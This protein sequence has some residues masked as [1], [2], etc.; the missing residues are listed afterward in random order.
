[1]FREGWLRLFF[2]CRYKRFITLVTA[3]ASCGTVLVIISASWHKEYFKM[4]Q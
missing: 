4:D 2:C 3:S 1:M